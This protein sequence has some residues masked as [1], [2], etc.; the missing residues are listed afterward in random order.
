MISSL[1]QNA[2]LD[3]TGS[4]WIELGA[5]MYALTLTQPDYCNAQHWRQHHNRVSDIHSAYPQHSACISVGATAVIMFPT[6]TLMHAHLINQS[7]D[8]GNLSM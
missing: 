4:G 7:I 8:M 5:G 3:I 1:W 2:C 6:A